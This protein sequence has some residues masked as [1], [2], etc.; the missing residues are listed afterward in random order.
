MEN[1]K[2]ILDYSKWISGDGGKFATGEGKVALLNKEGFMCCLGQWS[3]QLGVSEV[4]ILNNGE[5]SDLNIFIPGL[6][7]E[8]GCDEGYRN[9][10]FSD[11]AIAI[12]DDPDTDPETKINQ[13]SKL[14]K[15]NG[16][17][18]EV[19]NRPPTTE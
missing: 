15:D 4:A 3:L 13:L 5:P 16:F 19:I 7:I 18:L 1:K 11:D 8:R 14:C 9:A 6:N 2:L 10:Q 12:N 17:E